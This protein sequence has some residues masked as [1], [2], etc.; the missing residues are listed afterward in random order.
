[1]ARTIARGA[2]RKTV[3]ARTDQPRRQNQPTQ[4]ARPL[5]TF[6]PATGA[7]LG[8]A[9]NLNFGMS[10]TKFKL[11]Q[12]FCERWLPLGGKQ[13]WATLIPLV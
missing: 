6:R 9:F 8:V 13:P 7:A 3:L 11:P 12:H 4:D 2:G 1:M 5:R 10:F